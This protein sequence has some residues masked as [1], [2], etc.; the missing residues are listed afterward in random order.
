IQALA[1]AGSDLRLGASLGIC[2]L[3]AKGIDTPEAA[4]KKADELMYGAKSAGKNR[5]HS[6]PMAAVTA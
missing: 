5:Y 4:L 2:E 1:I 6:Q 3:A